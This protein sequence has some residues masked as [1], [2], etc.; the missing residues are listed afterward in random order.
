MA[1][2]GGCKETTHHWNTPPGI[3][4]CKKANINRKMNN[5][6]TPLVIRCRAAC[7]ALGLSPAIIYWIPPATITPTTTMPTPALNQS[8]I[9]W[10]SWVRGDWFKHFWTSC[11]VGVLAHGSVPE[12]E[13]EVVGVEVEELPV[14]G[15]FGTKAEAVCAAINPAA[16]NAKKARREK[17][18]ILLK[19]GIFIF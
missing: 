6:A 5:A 12:V 3:S 14:L 4:H 9:N 18:N 17:T 8:T 11:W 13:L 10:M 16:K 2:S 15:L 7:S 1:T 19:A